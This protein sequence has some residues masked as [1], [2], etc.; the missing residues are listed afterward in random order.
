MIKRQ[1]WI[2]AFENRFLA[3]ENERHLLQIRL[4]TTKIAQNEAKLS[5][6][7]LKTS[8]NTQISLKHPENRSGVSKKSIFKSYGKKTK[9]SCMRFIP[10]TRDNVGK[11]ARGFRERGILPWNQ[12]GEEYAVGWVAVDEGI[13]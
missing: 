11:H 5:R 12:P 4:K 10:S 1:N 13:D 7:M 8:K 6:I 9:I 3:A 2:I